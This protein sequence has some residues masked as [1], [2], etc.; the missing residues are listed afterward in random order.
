[1]QQ[2][3]AGVCSHCLTPAW[4]VRSD[5]ETATRIERSIPA[6][7]PAVEQRLRGFLELPENWNGYGE[8][9]INHRAVNGALGLLESLGPH[10]AKP[11]ASPLPDG[12]VQMEWIRDRFELEV[13]VRA[14]MPLALFFVD[15]DGN[16]T[17]Q[18]DASREELRLHLASMG[19]QTR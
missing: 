15:G 10:I 2:P 1:M 17:D 4:S 9:R 12:G 14:G 3:A 7:L 19:Y 13:E 6:W 11:I 8:Q 5:S 18:D 16:E